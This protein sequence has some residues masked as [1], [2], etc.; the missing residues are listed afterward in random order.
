MHSSSMALCHRHHRGPWLGQGRARVTVD[1]AGEWSY[2][3]KK[4]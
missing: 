2:L 1:L 3:T 4:A